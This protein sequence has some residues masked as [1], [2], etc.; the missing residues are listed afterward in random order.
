MDYL[1]QSDQHGVLAKDATREEVE[2]PIAVDGR[3]LPSQLRRVLRWEHAFLLALAIGFWGL[4][5]VRQTGAADFGVNTD[6]LGIYVGARTVATGH[7]AELY[8]LQAQRTALD[9][10][11]GTL[12]RKSLMPFIYPA[13]VGVLLSPLGR[14]PFV[15]A[16]QTWSLIN[17]A[18]ILWTVFRISNL[19]SADLRTR[20]SL[21]VVF[22]AWVPLQLTMFQGQ[23]GLLPTLGIVEAMLALRAGHEWRAGWWL[24][25]GLMKPQLILFPLLALV[26]WRCWRAV[27]A[28][29]IAAAAVSGI[30]LAIV[31]F[32]FPEYLRFLAEYN[33]L[34]PALS[35][36]PRAM[37][38]WRGLAC[39]LM[40][41]DDGH[42][43][44]LIVAMLTALSVATVVFVCS[45]R[46]SDFGVPGSSG[47]RREAEFAV[48][49]LLGLLSS[50]HLYMHDWVVALPAGLVLWRYARDLYGE[51][52]SRQG[53]T[54]TLTLLWLIGVAPAIFFI[55]Q[56]IY[57]G[58]KVPVYGAVAVVVATCTLYASR[59]S[60]LTQ[61]EG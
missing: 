18:V 37:Q 52:K 7:G 2:A 56:F 11:L 4:F 20:L 14:L 46:R 57:S 41:R 29:A 30:S 27:A 28:F 10:A 3:A 24:S 13:Y 55:G 48:A 1:P 21:L 31:G 38:N 25:L 43:V 42:A 35:L 22:L 50:P 15:T 47:F 9:A 40:N 34:G 49:I 32:W 17:L 58:P 6:F 45:R 12:H 60:P 8:E 36:Y 23:L 33:R 44:W 61:L 51:G 5:L 19:F 39:W 59:K 53:W 26:V 16:L 54:I